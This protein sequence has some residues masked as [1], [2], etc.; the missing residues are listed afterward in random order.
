V[1]RG[2]QDAIAARIQ[3]VPAL[4]IDGRYLMNNEAAGRN[5]LIDGEL[6]KAADRMIAKARLDRKGK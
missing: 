2:D 4:V 1:Q 6:L 5:S 3:G